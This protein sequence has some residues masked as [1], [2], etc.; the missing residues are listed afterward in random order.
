MKD[1]TSYFLME[2]TGRGSVPFAEMGN[3][4]RAGFEERWSIQFGTH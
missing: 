1:K 3:A 2:A 4:E